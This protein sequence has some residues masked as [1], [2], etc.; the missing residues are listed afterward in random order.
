[1]TKSSPFFISSNA[2]T[3][4]AA[5][6]LG[7]IVLWKSSRRD[8]LTVI[9]LTF[10]INV[11]LILLKKYP[12]GGS[13]HSIYL[14]PLAA[15]LVG[16]SVQYICGLVWRALKFS[17]MPGR[18]PWVESRIVLFKNVA[19]IFLLVIPLF[20]TLAFKESEYLRRY[21]SESRILS[22]LLLTLDFKETESLLRLSNS[23]KSLPEFPPETRTV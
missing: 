14:L 15:L 1:L 9:V 3:G 16:A 21:K 11:I 13:R 12:F 23:T 17:D 7:F 2:V 8:V 18:Y 22:P 6:V 10:G 20:I 4:A 5:A 19:L